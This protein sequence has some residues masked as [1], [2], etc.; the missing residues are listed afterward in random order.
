[1]NITDGNRLDGVLLDEFI[2]IKVRK[3]ALLQEVRSNT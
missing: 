3:Y 1:M 2:D